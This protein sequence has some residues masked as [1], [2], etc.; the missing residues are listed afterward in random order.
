MID[1]PLM[2]AISDHKL[3]L[4]ILWRFPV[5]CR[6]EVFFSPIVCLLQRLAVSVFDAQYGI[7][8]AADGLGAHSDL[9]IVTLHRCEAKDILFTSLGNAAV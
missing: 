1:T 9:Q 4:T 7:K 6:V 5:Q 8:G 2:K 3:E